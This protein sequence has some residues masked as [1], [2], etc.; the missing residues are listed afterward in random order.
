MSHESVSSPRALDV[1]FVA[2]VELTADV[3]LPSFGVDRGPSPLVA[4]LVATIRAL[5][6]LSALAPRALGRWDAVVASAS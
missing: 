1:G 4:T 3:S 6:H 5:N 2:Y